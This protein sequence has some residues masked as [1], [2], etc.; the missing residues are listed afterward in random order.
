MPGALLVSDVVADRFAA[1]LDASAPDMPHVVLR[2]AGVDGDPAQVEA[3]FFSGDLYPER[4]RDFALALAKATRLRW[5]HTM[6]AGVDHPWFRAMIE[7]G[8]VVTTSPGAAARPIAQTVLAYVLA[9]SRD[10]RRFDDAQRRR[11]W[12]PH[13]VED[14]AEQ[15]LGVVGLGPIGLHV[16]RLAAA[17]E[18]RVIGMRRAPRG[19]EPC[20][21][22]PLARLDELLACADWLVLALPLTERTR[23][24][25]DA[26]ALARMKP[27][28]RLVNVGRGAL[29]DEA[30][31]GEALAAGRL[32]GAALDV[33]ETEPLPSESALWSMPNVIVTPHCSG[34][35]PGNAVRAAEIFVDNLARFARGAPLLHVAE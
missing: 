25:V 15:T 22:W 26:R 14:L 29:V 7:R 31:L 19:D 6:S 32:A 33:F 1:Q 5:L 30:A 23:H 12:E 18:M 21:T 13:A 17:F 24:L 27:G 35:N 28:A 34:Q 3:A 11:A 16:A 10:L 8:V 20:E 9:L 2:A 4:V